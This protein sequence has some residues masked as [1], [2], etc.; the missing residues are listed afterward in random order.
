MKKIELGVSLWLYEE[1]SVWVL[2]TVVL[3]DGGVL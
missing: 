2:L 1:I 3:A